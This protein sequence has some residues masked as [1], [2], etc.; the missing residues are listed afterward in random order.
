MLGEVR[1][2]NTVTP[3]SWRSLSETGRAEGGLAAS[4]RGAGSLPAISR[5]AAEIKLTDADMKLLRQ[6]ALETMR[7]MSDRAYQL[8]EPARPRWVDALRLRSGSGRVTPETVA[9]LQNQ[10]R[11]LGEGQGE[12]LDIRECARLSLQMEKLAGKLPAG[13]LLAELSQ[14]LALQGQAAWAQLARAEAE[15]QLLPQFQRFD[16]PGASQEKH[17]GVSVGAG[18]GSQHG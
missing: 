9:I 12:T 11:Q 17:V 2:N 10:I 1:T 5:A 16:R 13:S 8:A 18:L 6:G 3:L 4:L 14:R 15:T 7:A